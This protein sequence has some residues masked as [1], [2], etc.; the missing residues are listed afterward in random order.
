MKY[1]ITGANVQ[2][3]TLH[4]I[5]TAQFKTIA[6]RPSFSLLNKDKLEQNGIQA[7]EWDLGLKRLMMEIKGN[8]GN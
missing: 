6:K 5:T 4:R 2:N 3:T 7:L 8:C 1:L